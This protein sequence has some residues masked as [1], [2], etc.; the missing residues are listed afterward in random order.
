M[1]LDAPC[2]SDRLSANQDD[3]NIFATDKTTERLDLP[4]KQT[5]MLM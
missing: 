1:L 2:T 3:N 5:K 4:Q